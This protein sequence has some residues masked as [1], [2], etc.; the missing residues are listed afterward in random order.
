MKNEEGFLVIA[1]FSLV[2]G[3]PLIALICVAFYAMA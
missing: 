3:Y 2:F 1:F